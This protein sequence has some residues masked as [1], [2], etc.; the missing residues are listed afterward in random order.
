MD[1]PPIQYAHTVDG[2]NIAYWAIGDGPTL[3]LHHS[4]S[5]SHIEQEWR[6]TYTREFYLALARHFRV[7]RFD[8]RG[9]GLSDRSPSG[10]SVNECALDF[11]AVLGAIGPEPAAIAG[12]ITVGVPV[13]FT[14]A[15]PARVSHLVLW[16]PIARGADYV[17]LPST[18][19]TRQL[20]AVDPVL[21]TE[22]FA[23]LMVGLD[24]GA[25]A[26]EFAELLQRV[27]VTNDDGVR[28]ASYDYDV[29]ERLSEVA[30]P[31]L[32]LHPSQSRL[33]PAAGARRIAGAISG[34]SW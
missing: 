25:R 21:G 29:S 17:E 1:A 22:A 3:I 10:Y 30:V 14:L 2:L 32:V 12:E 26:K 19:L 16:S 18:E 33:I 6:T 15:A 27:A 5:S 34:S 23:A 28:D 4:P 11:D 9:C 8:Q 7:V 24:E 31:T 20:R 13:L